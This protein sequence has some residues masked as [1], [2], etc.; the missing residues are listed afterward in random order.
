MSELFVIKA[1]NTAEGLWMCYLQ[2]I[3]LSITL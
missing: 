2:Q 3:Q 1:E